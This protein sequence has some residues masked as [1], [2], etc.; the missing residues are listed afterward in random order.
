M[1]LTHFHRQ[2]SKLPHITSCTSACAI[3]ISILWLKAAGR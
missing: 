2:E 1:T 3:L